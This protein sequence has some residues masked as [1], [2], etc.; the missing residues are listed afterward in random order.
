MNDRLDYQNI[1]YSD[2]G[3]PF[4]YQIAKHLTGD[5]LELLKEPRWHEAM[6]IKYFVKG[7]AELTCGPRVFIARAGDIV[8]INSCERH[9]I[10][11][12]SDDET[13]YHLL[14]VD[15]QMNL[16]GS[17]GRMLTP[18][19]EGEMRF[20]NLIS[21][22]SESGKRLSA[23]LLS[24][25]DEFAS[26]N[27]AHQLY[28]TGLMAQ[29]YAELIRSEVAQNIPS[30]EPDNIRRYAERI[31]EAFVTI[32]KHYQ[33]DLTLEDLAEPCGMSP[34]Y[35]CRIFKA[36][37]G[38][39]PVA[40]LNEYRISKAEILLRSSEIGISDIALA[41]GFADVCYFSRCF[42]RLRGV[43][44]KQYRSNYR[45]DSESEADVFQL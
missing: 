33:E 20:N 13:I 44:P 17:A 21:G 34:Y 43:S 40:Y 7:C 39:T 15:P 8:I 37:T 11:P 31:E 6:E 45:S 3:L 38:C 19:S 29:F 10:R 4:N 35:F 22:E 32:N 23:L 36:V 14:L 2:L 9:S 28:I 27:E 1:I 24:V 18:I 41:V 26:E 16:S 12:I 25:F 42:K 5:E 30:A